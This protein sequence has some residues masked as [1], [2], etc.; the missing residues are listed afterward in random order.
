LEV[1]ILDT[2]EYNG[3]VYTRTKTKWVDSRNLVV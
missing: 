2:I 3:E 1:D